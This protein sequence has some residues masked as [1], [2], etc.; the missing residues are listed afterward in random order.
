MHRSFRFCLI[1]KNASH[2]IPQLK[3]FKKTCHFSRL[4]ACTK[5]L[6]S[7]CRTPRHPYTRRE[8]PRLA[9]R[10]ARADIVRP[11][12]RGSIGR[13]QV[14]RNAAKSVITQHLPQCLLQTMVVCDR[15][16]FRWVGK[17]VV[18]DGSPVVPED[19][20]HITLPAC[21]CHVACRCGVDCWPRRWY[22]RQHSIVL[23]HCFRSRKRGSC[24][25]SCRRFARGVC[26]P[27]RC[28][29]I[30]RAYSIQR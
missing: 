6:W 4:G 3:S 23:E 30:P 20:L 18:H 28:D 7:T 25:G 10:A 21:C 1:R 11:T 27:S 15:V 19:K 17:D 8:R 12:S 13:W 26:T 9:F 5:R 2:L 14:C 22:R 16:L 24:R 29:S